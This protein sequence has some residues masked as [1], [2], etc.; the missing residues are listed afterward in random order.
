MELANAGQEKET[1]GYDSYFRTT[2]WTAVLGAGAADPSVARE[3]FAGLYQQYWTPLYA[4]VRRR[5]YPPVEAEDLTQEFLVSLIESGALQGF[6]R[7][8]G[9]FR[10]F[11]IKSLSNFLS[12]VWKRTQAQKRGGG[13]IAVSLD[14]RD[15]ELSL[16]RELKLSEDPVKCFERRWVSALLEATMR[17]LEKYYET[18]GK[19]E[20]FR[21]IHPYLQD[22]RGG[23]LYAEAAARIHMQEGAFKA[24][25]HRMRGVYGR[26]LREEVARTVSSP[27]EIEEEIRYL[28]GVVSS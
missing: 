22:G 8:G 16:E 18:R 6:V 13:M 17:R 26:L 25:V 4:Y 15:I 2:H 19:L 14:V 9:K 7:E 1:Q 3:A 10:S 24:A 21:A 12:N 5:G 27:G 20:L 11:L 28:I 23:E